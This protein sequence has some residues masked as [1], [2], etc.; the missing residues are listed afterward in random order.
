VFSFP[1]EFI[2][3]KENLQV[4]LDQ[5][6][7]DNAYHESFFLRGIY[8]TGKASL[9][10]KI[11][12]SLLPNLNTE[13]EFQDLPSERLCFITD[14]FEK[15]I[16]AESTLAQPVMRILVSTNRMLNYAKTIA[17]AIGVFWFI[18][19][20]FAHDNLK[21]GLNTTLPALTQID[22]SI[23]GIS[24]KG[25]ISD[26]PR[27]LVYLNQQA[28]I[29]LEKFAAVDTVN[30]GSIFIPASWFSH[31]N[32]NIRLAFSAA[33]DRI[34]LPSLY[35][36][37]L[38][39]TEDIV[40]LKKLEYPGSGNKQS[41]MN[42][43]LSQSF[44]AIKNYIQQIQ[45]LEKHVHNFNNLEHSR[46]IQ[47]LAGLIKYLFNKDLPPQF[48]TSADY[49]SSALSMSLERPIDLTPFKT[50][51]GQKL[52]L[53]YKNFIEHAFNLDESFP[54][55]SSISR[56]LTHLAD[57]GQTRAYDS[58]DLR[59][60]VEETIATADIISSGSLDWA[61]KDVFD[62]GPGYS[63]L[64]NQITTSTLLGKEIASEL[65]RISEREFVKFK[66]ALASFT[67][68]LTGPLF[69]LRNGQLISDPS[70][71][72]IHFI[73][74][75]SMFLDEP[76]MAKSLDHQLVT[77][78][79]AG[80]LLFW[81]DLILQKST[82]LIE[83]FDEFMTQR[84]NNMPPSLQSI[85]KLVGRNSMRKY[86]LNYVAQSQVLN[87][88]PSS[89]MGLGSR[90]LL[91]AQVL[92]LNK[93]VPMFSRIFSVF[94]EGGL[95]TE[96]TK[97]RQLLVN[98][99]QHILQK[100][101]KMLESDDLYAAREDMFMWWDGSPMVGLKAFGVR[102]LNEMKTF[103]K[104]QRLRI[105]FLAKELAE[106][107]LSLLSI[108]YLEDISFDVPLVDW[109]TRIIKAIDEYEKKTPGSSLV[110]LEHF[111]SYDVNEITLENCSAL[112]LQ[113]DFIGLNDYFVDI[114]NTITQQLSKRCKNVTIRRAF[115]HYNKAA[116]FF[117]TN[118][119]GRFP[120]SRKSENAD[121]FEAD[122]NDV[123]IFFDLFDTLDHQEISALE[124]YL[125]L[126]NTDSEAIRFIKDIQSIRTLM[127]AALDQGPGQEPSKID[128][129]VS[130][131]TDRKRE[132][133]GDKIIDWSLQ[134]GGSSLRFSPKSFKGFLV[135][136]NANSCRFTLGS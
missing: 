108:G 69:V 21:T 31:L 134:V 71:G 132:A 72:L 59:K 104:A 130:F 4:Y 56:K 118:L 73:D 101:E 55:F 62:P 99:S 93:V 86:V 116:T 95:V 52:G 60:I 66:L 74:Y 24:L 102:D 87:D 17:A 135:Y 42:P 16:F 36:A 19:L 18:G 128:F 96:N 50:L 10:S 46:N 78:I 90:E 103:L 48:Y 97:L 126:G 45:S 88:E 14:L 8:L 65:N 12:P 32:H 123:A 136:G 112:D 92:N 89:N 2:Q 53:I 81:D 35:S 84:L 115:E 117:N 105:N 9:N 63:F 100:I 51:A 80:K 22:R 122:S 43:L 61:D 121:N 15:K 113:D 75:M 58:D 37:I 39:K 6:F 5:I 129:E 28:D 98:E 106:P 38:K 111:L 124:K 68:P 70:P 79:P 3:L 133:G 57:I 85:M 34:I 1:L 23:Q 11:V 41:A 30:V 119:A 83:N 82:K 54:I 49:Y 27:F 131:R 110:A 13:K 40:S 109:W 64:I 91:H 44:Q 7:K 125:R 26:D 47:D 67:T 77:K 94:D 114:R 127:L 29:I 25:G 20:I 107:I 33:Y 120:F 76:F